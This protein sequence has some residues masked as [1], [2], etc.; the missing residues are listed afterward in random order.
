M[1]T[2]ALGS[3]T[4]VT[5]SGFHGA[6]EPEPPSLENHFNLDVGDEYSSHAYVNVNIGPDSTP[7]LIWKNS[8]LKQVITPYIPS[9]V[10]KNS[11]RHAKKPSLK[12]KE[13]SLL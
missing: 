2:H 12:P 13:D 1:S 3:Y 5:H 4:A 6:T 11:S 8:Y 9:A 7:V 10:I